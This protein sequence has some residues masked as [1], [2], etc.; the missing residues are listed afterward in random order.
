M[1]SPLV[2]T[3][4]VLSIASGVFAQ[5]EGCGKAIPGDIELGTS[6]NQTI[7][8]ESGHTPRRYR[9]RV[10]KTYDNSVPVPL[11][12]SYHGR[13]KD[14]KFQEKLSQFGNASYG[15]EGISVFPNGVPV[16]CAI[17]L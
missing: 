3:S 11:I 12:L 9:I 1:R 17:T 4:A 10:P 5:S 13:G 7:D 2:L 14:M 6:K 15:F 8:S 16:S